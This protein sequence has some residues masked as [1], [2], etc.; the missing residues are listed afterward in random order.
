MGGSQLS[1]LKA[2]LHS[3]GA[4]G[5]QREN[6]KKK[7]NSNVGRSKGIDE[8]ARKAKL[9]VSN[10]VESYLFALLTRF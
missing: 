5:Q 9:E 1:Q 10:C 6:R 7:S 4:T 2:A 8:D 3:S